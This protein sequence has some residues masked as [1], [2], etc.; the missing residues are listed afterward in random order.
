MD[1]D[2]VVFGDSEKC[3]PD[4]AALLA[5]LTVMATVVEAALTE[6]AIAVVAALTPA[7]ALP[8][9]A[10]FA[11]RVVLAAEKAAEQPAARPRAVVASGMVVVV[12]VLVPESNQTAH[13][14]RAA[15]F[16]VRPRPTRV[17]VPAA[18]VA[19][20][21]LPPRAAAVVTPTGPASVRPTR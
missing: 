18:A 15:R 4:D 20:S 3:D 13:A 5:E 2:D 17:A 1:P 10:R 16:P 6:I 11:S 21:A 19:S 8:H 7:L 12:L 14:T 9:Q